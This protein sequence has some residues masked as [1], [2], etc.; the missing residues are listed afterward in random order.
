MR[1]AVDIVNKDTGI[2]T[3]IYPSAIS[4]SNEDG[5]ITVKFIDKTIN[6]VVVNRYDDTKYELKV[7]Y[8][9][10]TIPQSKNWDNI[11]TL[12][13]LLTDVQKN[14]LKIIVLLQK[15][16]VHHGM[17]DCVLLPKPNTPDGYT[18]LTIAKDGYM[19]GGD[20]VYSESYVKPFGITL[21]FNE[22]LSMMLYLL[23]LDKIQ[24]EVQDLLYT[25]SANKTEL[26]MLISDGI[27]KKSDFSIYSSMKERMKSN[28]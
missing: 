20:A 27:L 5:N 24:T 19:Y 23:D 7:S 4:V 9:G 8:Y 21:S 18:I 14:D 26:N 13:E 1:L 11:K 15:M 25:A 12:D 6:K 3:A 22:G 10:I 28:A 16:T 2:T 17:V